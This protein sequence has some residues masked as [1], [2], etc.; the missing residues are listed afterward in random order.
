MEETL[1]NI[2]YQGLGV[3]SITKDKIEKAV[4]ELVEKGKLTREEGKKFADEIGTETRKAGEEFKDNVKE[5]ARE[6]IEKSG[7]PSREEFE[8]LKARVE[9][10]EQKLNG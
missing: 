1:K 2:M 5:T 6:W 8:S 3:I 10:L 4:N 7:I 9:A